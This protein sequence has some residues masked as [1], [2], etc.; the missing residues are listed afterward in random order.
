MSEV[1]VALVLVFCTSF[2]ALL[3][4]ICGTLLVYH[5]SSSSVQT[6]QPS[7]PKIPADEDM[8]LIA[9]VRA[10]TEELQSDDLSP[11]FNPESSLQELTDTLS[12]LTAQIATSV[13]SAE[14][15]SSKDKR[16]LG[17]LLQPIPDFIS[18]ISTMKPNEIKAVLQGDKQEDEAQY[19]SD[20]LDRLRGSDQ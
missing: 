1:L 8:D 15:I 14:Q 17:N 11:Q 19:L 7:R 2:F 18:Q 3:G 6:F 16:E 13:D 9:S 20:V 5:L 10:A 4:S 12:S